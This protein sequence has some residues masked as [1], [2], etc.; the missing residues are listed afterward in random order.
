MDQLT[1]ATEDTLSQTPGRTPATMHLAIPD[2]TQQSTQ[3]KKSAVYIIVSNIQHP[4]GYY[5]YKIG[6]TSETQKYLENRYRTSQKYF[7][8][9]W[10]PLTQELDRIGLSYVDK[11]MKESLEELNDLVKCVVPPQSLEGLETQLGNLKLTLIKAEY[12]NT[13]EVYKFCNN[14]ERMYNNEMFEEQMGD[15]ISFFDGFDGK[16]T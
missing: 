12:I 16:E 10:K 1:Q 14:T 6:I 15:L 9:Y 13:G 7:A 8:I 11:Q 2:Y 4:C 3:K 5:L